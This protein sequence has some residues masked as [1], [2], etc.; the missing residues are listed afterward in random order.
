MASAHS[1]EKT[2]RTM[3]SMN[4]MRGTG[5]SG[6]PNGSAGGAS[7]LSGTGSSNWRFERR[8]KW[9][10]IMAE[11]THNHPDQAEPRSHRETHHEDRT[12]D[13]STA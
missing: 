4:K 5:N 7:T 3:H 9:K 13:L 2:H 6:N 10:A 8:N 12:V 1:Y 11:Y